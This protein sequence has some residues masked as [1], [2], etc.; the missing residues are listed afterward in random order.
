M[1]FSAVT[2]GFAADIHLVP[3][4]DGNH[5]VVI[6][7]PMVLGDEYKFAS[8]I[9]G[10]SKLTIS[11]NSPGG[12]TDVAL[13]IGR[14]IRQRHYA[15]LVPQGTICASACAMVWIA[16][17]PRKMYQTSRIGFHATFVQTPVGYAISSEGNALVGAYY[18]EMGL[19]SAA[20][21]YFTQA[22]P[23]SIKWLSAADASKIELEFEML[24]SNA[25]ATQNSLSSIVFSP[26]GGSEPTGT[27]I[28]PGERAEIAGA[29]YN[30]LHGRG[31]ESC[32]SACMEDDQCVGLNLYA[33]GACTLLSRATGIQ[34]REGVSSWAKTK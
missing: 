25:L 11:L 20:I 26:H 6:N 22:A 1:L 4:D 33:D 19:G 30:V 12:L 34:F 27:I 29:P 7:G 3:S 5:M 31:I 23:K 9:A 28:R 18:G 24:S 8:A 10:F 16:G 13:F 2:T 14:V 17:S 21:V 32:R 15:T